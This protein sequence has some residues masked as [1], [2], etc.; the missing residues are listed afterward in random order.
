MKYCLN[1]MCKKEYLEQA[2]EIYIPYQHRDLIY[3]VLDDYPKADIIIDYAVEEGLPWDMLIAANE[4]HNNRLII[5]SSIPNELAAAKAAGIRAF[6]R[7]AI[8]SFYDLNALKELGVCYVYLQPPLFFDM[9]NVK[10]VGIPVRAVPNWAYDENYLPRPHGIH[11]TWIRPE[12]IKYYENYVG[13]CEF[14]TYSYDKDRREKEQTLFRIYKQ[15]FWPEDLSLVV[16]GLNCY[17]DNKYVAQDRLMPIRLN[18]RQ[19]C[20]V[21]HHC[22]ICERAL[23][24]GFTVKQYHENLKQPDLS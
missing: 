16:T 17:V 8:S 21:N 14:R 20:E 5:C 18:C 11:G 22:H 4:T 12:D 2:D 19:M 9:D 24:F 15:G 13:A 1:C 3:D 10:K 23:D 7:H 6:Y